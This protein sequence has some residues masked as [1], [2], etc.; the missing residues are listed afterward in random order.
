MALGKPLIPLDLS[1]LTSR[2][3][4]ASSSYL[5]G[6]CKV[7][8]TMYKKNYRLLTNITYDVIFVTPRTLT[9]PKEL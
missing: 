3:Y 6:F 7:Q 4:N 9:H 5:K 8:M 2:R 1:S